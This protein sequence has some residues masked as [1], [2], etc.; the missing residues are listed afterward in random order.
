MSSI[1]NSIET[2]LKCNVE[3]KMGPLAELMH[4]ELA[5]KASP[6]LSDRLKGTFDSRR[7]FDHPDEVKKEPEKYK[8]TPSA[9]ER[10]CSKVPTQTSKESIND[11]QRLENACRQ[12]LKSTRQV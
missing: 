12:F 6:N 3:V 2:V 1:T 10:L 5:L 4:G 7:N 11:E 8:N 9:D